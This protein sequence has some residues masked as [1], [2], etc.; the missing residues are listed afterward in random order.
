MS[1][2]LNK[3]SNKL[4]KS[5][6]TTEIETF[7]KV[8]KYDLVDLYHNII[9]IQS[10]L[11]YYIYQI[12]EN[13]QQYILFN[14]HLQGFF[15]IYGEN[16]N[17]I[18]SSLS[19]NIT[20]IYNKCKNKYEICLKGN[21]NQNKKVTSSSSLHKVVIYPYINNRD[22]SIEITLK[23]SI[24][25]KLSTLFNQWLN[26]FNEYI[27]LQKSYAIEQ[28][29][30]RDIP[31]DENDTIKQ[32]LTANLFQIKKDIE[33]KKYH[34]KGGYDG[35]MK[36]ILD[37]FTTFQQ[38]FLIDPLSNNQQQQDELNDI[39]IIEQDQQQPQQVPNK[40]YE[41][42]LNYDITQKKKKKKKKEKKMLRKK[43]TN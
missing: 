12:E 18:Y 15:H 11:L 20:D 32:Q 14:K 34:L 2:I 22:K 28:Q 16:N 13:Y 36:Q 38:H 4:K 39:K 10:H 21:Q 26:E 7:I 5:S 3:L 29:I 33:S 9:D 43:N 17:T 27:Q 35:Y 41:K 23:S 40:D 24:G 1:K 30:D 42:W 19:N 37:E 6:K 25:I 8:E 31:I